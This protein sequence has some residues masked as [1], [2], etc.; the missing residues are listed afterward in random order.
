MP[1]CP[2][3]YGKS[4]FF[5]LLCC[6]LGSCGIE[7]KVAAEI[8]D[9]FSHDDDRAQVTIFNEEASLLSYTWY[10]STDTGFG[11]LS[12]RSSSVMRVQVVPAGE[13]IRIELN[14]SSGHD[15]VMYV[16]L[17]PNEE[18]QLDLGIAPVLVY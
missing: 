7:E 9:V 11:N 8:N 1:V 10:A 2:N 6:L 17:S 4:V 3:A 5:L 15:R 12:A 14:W 13:T 18:L 16:H